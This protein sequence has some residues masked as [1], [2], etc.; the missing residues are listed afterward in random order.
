MC[1]T[2]LRE[3]K[4]SALIRNLLCVGKTVEGGREDTEQ[5]VE[6]LLVGA[7]GQARVM[8]HKNLAVIELPSK[9]VYSEQSLYEYIICIIH[10]S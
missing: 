5:F 3:L 6:L 8:D 10:L 7:H 4:L 1:F 2:V 9:E